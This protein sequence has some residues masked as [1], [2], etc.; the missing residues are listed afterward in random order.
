[1][2]IELSLKSSFSLEDAAK[3]I[4][5]TLKQNLTEDDYLQLA[6]DRR[7]Q[8]CLPGENISFILPLG[9][10]EY[11]D[12]ELSSV[13]LHTLKTAKWMDE[14]TS[15]LAYTFPTCVLPRVECFYPI[16]DLSTALY[17]GYGSSPQLDLF[18][19]KGTLV[20]LRDGEVGLAFKEGGCRS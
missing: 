12:E 6:L 4:N 13:S 18:A 3:R 10:I 15:R 20:Q 8:T 14:E 9:K 11:T 16:V 5:R 17:A 7:I 2:D 19:P 1:M